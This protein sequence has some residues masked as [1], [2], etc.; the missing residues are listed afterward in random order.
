MNGISKGILAL[1][2]VVFIALFSSII[3]SNPSS[4]TDSRTCSNIFGDCSNSTTNDTCKNDCSGVE[5]DGT[6]PRVEEVHINA[7][8]FFT[9]DGINV[10]CQFN[11]VSGATSYEYIWY[12]NYSSWIKIANWTVTSGNAQGSGINKSI[13]FKLNS[14][15]NTH[16]VRCIISWGGSEVLDQCAN[17]EGVY[18][19]N[20]DVNFTVTNHLTY[21]FWNL[22]NYTDG[23]AIASGQN[24][25]RND[26]INASAKWNK[27]INNAWMTHDGNGSSVNYTVSTL[28]N[29]TNYTLNFS[30]GTEFSRTGNITVSTIYANDTYSATNNTSPSLFFYLWGFSKVAQVTSNQTTLYNNTSARAFCKIIDNI[31]SQ[32]INNSNVSFYGNDN[33]LNWSLTNSSGYAN[34]SFIVNAT[35]LPSNYSVKCNITDQ[36]SLYYN[37][38]SQ[39]SNSTNISVYSPYEINISDFWFSYGG[40]TVNKTNLLSN[41]TIYANVSDAL[42]VSSVYANFSYPSGSIIANSSMNGTNSSGYNLWNYTFGSQY[43]LNASGNYSVRIIANNSYGI[44]NVSDFKIFYVNN[45]YDLNFSTNYSTYN[46]GENIT[47]QVRDVNDFP[48]YNLNWT[49]NLTRFNQ[50]TNTTNYTN[51]NYTYTI[52]NDDLEGNYTLSVNASKNNNTANSSWQ[53]NVSKNL[54]L[55]ISTNPS[56]TPPRSSTVTVSASLYNARG[57]LYNLSINANISCD[58]GVTWSSLNFTSGQ[59]S[60]SCIAPSGY[61]APFNI[62]INATDNYNNTGENYTT[63]TTEAQ[64]VVYTSSGGSGGFATSK[65]ETIKN[66]TDGTQYSQCSAK[67]P[68]YCSNGT[69]VRKCSICGCANSDYGCQPDGSCAL[70][71]EEDFNFNLSATRLEIKQGGDKEIT[72]VLKNTGN[73]VLELMSFYNASEYCCNISMPPSFEL[74]EKEEKAFTISIHAPLFAVVGDYP[75]TTISIGT[76]LFRKDKTIDII[77]GQSPHY[78]SL[79]E[80]ENQLADIEN[81]IQEIKKAG[82]DT[83]SLEA[84]VEKSRALLQNANSS[85]ASDQIDVLSASLANLTS[86]NQL[87]ESKLSGLRNQAFLLQNAWLIGLFVIMSLTTMYMVPQ[88]LLPLNKKEKQLSELKEEEETLVLSR[89]ETEKQYFMRKIDEN[90]FSKIMIGK[91]DRILKLRTQIREKEN[92]RTQLIKAVSP[93]A[94]ATWLANGIKGI[95]KKIKNSPKSIL[96]RKNKNNIDDNGKTQ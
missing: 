28:A 66:C 7:T 46:R 26:L 48:V 15:E 58:S 16:I 4:F 52:A 5:Y 39:N 74:K 64:Q 13:S 55:A 8:N 78:N 17:G 49:A 90:T 20:D 70:I 91:Q 42:S 88:I 40:V 23:S 3:F 68:Y 87:V 59:A 83:S 95:P 86:N 77:V 76:N 61:S 85:I 84:M 11:E 73:T 80:L 44:T 31:T 81:K 92:E 93:L 38:S 29:W 32:G 71:K 65:K 19:D 56:S 51:A 45:T 2:I 34:L 63:L 82:I 30:N 21:N 33:F 6:G 89:V 37:A 50:T 72:G 1:A 18:Y 57:E 96:N 14:S 47:A 27:I 22:T 41:L 10:T 25:T 94:M 53:F 79:S 43:P 60:Y 24:Y 9:G 69:L 36:P 35:S 75:N 12:Y 54:S 67:R 62:D